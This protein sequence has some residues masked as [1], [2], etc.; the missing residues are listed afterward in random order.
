MPAPEPAAAS[1]YNADATD[2]VVCLE[3]IDEPL[4][5][6]CLHMFCSDCIR[7]IASGPVHMRKCPIC[8]SDVRYASGWALCSF[9]LSFFLCMY[10]IRFLFWRLG[11]CIAGGIS[12]PVTVCAVLA[13][14]CL[15]GQP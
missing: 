2:C 3:M 11:L 9:F 7:N 5:T 15:C 4:Q 14:F 13:P 1:A 8:R 12:L 10:Q 6:A